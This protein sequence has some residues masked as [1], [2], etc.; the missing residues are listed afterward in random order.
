MKGKKRNKIQKF[1]YFRNE[2]SS[3]RVKK[4]N[5]YFRM[6]EKGYLN[7]NYTKIRWIKN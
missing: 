5:L 3:S 2:K 4:R 7:K 1:F 6:M